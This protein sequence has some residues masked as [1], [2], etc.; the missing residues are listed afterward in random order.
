MEYKK[1]KI[2]PKTFIRKDSEKEND[3]SSDSSSTHSGEIEPDTT[4]LTTPHISIE[5]IEHIINAKIKDPF[6]YRRALTH[7]SI[8]GVIKH[9][10]YTQNEI[11]SY[12][13]ESNERLEFL[14]DIV[15]GSSITYYLFN[16]YPDKDEGFLT[17]VRTRIVKASAMEKFAEK[18][19][20]KGKILMS[21]YVIKNGGLEN[22]R[23][24]EDAFEA[25]VG[26]IRLDLGLDAA[27]AFSMNIIEKC[28]VENEILKDDNYKDL[29]L[30]FT[31]FKKID[32]PVYNCIEIEGP[33][34][35]RTFTMELKMYDKVYG[36]AKGKTKKRAE[37]LSAK[38]AIELLGIV[39]NFNN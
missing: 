6:W 39:D 7:K 37:Q 12:M 13:K 18:I 17:K 11:C 30:R 35:K 21:Q 27:H 28:V 8:Q 16:K 32:S 31:Q 23:F 25:M 3:S 33:P 29:L 1:K 34:H 24:L 9:S 19:G 15:F 4:D 38:Q 10:N 14:G 2:I 36:T 22:K 20:I 26:A 5:E